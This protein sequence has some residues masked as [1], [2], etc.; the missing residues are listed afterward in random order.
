MRKSIGWVILVGW[1]AW[2]VWYQAQ[3]RVHE[4]DLGAASGPHEIAIYTTFR[5]TTWMTE[6]LAHAFAATVCVLPDE[7]DPVT[8][9]PSRDELLAL[10]AAHL[11]VLN[12]A[13]LESWV[14][15]ASLPRS[16]VVDTSADFGDELIVAGAT[17][18]SHGGQAA[19]S[20]EGIDPHVWLD[21]MLLRRQ[22][23]AIR[24]ALVARFPE[25]T[26]A[27]E[28]GYAE[29]VDD[30]GAWGESLAGL[31]PALRDVRLLC[32]HPAYDYLARRFGWKLSNL[33]LD[34][35]APLDDEQWE[36]VRGAAEGGPGR[37]VMLWESQPLVET[38]RRL[39][40]ELSIASVVFTPGE[41][42]AIGEQRGLRENRDWIRKMHENIA[43]LRRAAA[44][45]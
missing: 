27:V 34:P 7:G 25:H 4:R 39:Q 41:S 38:A 32:A 42:F 37:R 28:T 30:I 40:D 6:R 5:P 23:T 15:N 19:H 17:M 44:G 12:G 8:W 35:D 33:D 14:A 31:G 2:F 1:V 13:G 10:Q 9:Q 36:Q 18:H 24:D 11:I 26:V 22:A 3:H 45:D 21:P 43:R 20:H 29:L 16:R